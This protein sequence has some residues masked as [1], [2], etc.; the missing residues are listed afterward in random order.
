MYTRLGTE[1][2]KLT[3]QWRHN[4]PDG[5]SNHRRPYCLLNRLFRRR[6]KKHQSAESLAMV[7]GIHRLPVDSPQKGPITWKIFPSDDV[8]MNWTACVLD[9]Q[10]LAHGAFMIFLWSATEKNGWANN[11]DAGDLGHHCAHYD[12]IVILY[13]ISSIWFQI[14]QHVVDL[15]EKSV[16]GQ[17]MASCCQVTSYRFSQ[18]CPYMYVCVIR[19]IINSLRSSDAYMRRWPGSSLVQAIIWTNAGIL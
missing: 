17:I 11:R 13:I 2:L 5:I 12:V 9:V 15:V 14:Y 18:C 3:L 4:W 7:M 16:L 8:I 19:V 6:S 1:K 10:W